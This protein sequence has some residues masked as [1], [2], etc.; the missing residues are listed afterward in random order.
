MRFVKTMNSE[1]FDRGNFR[2]VQPGQWIVQNGVK[3]RVA[4]VTKKGVILV[5][6]NP[7][8]DD[9]RLTT[10]RRLLALQA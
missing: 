1:A 9:D 5:V 2:R 6:W 7:K 10:M 4:G 3:G 8:V